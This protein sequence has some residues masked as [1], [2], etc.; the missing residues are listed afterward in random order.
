[1]K[2]SILLFLVIF[3][4]TSVSAN[5]MEVMP[6]SNNVL[7]D[8]WVEVYN[9]GN[10]SL[11][12]T[13]IGDSSSNDSISL[14]LDP[15]SFGLIIDSSINC[16]NF[17]VPCYELTTIGNG[18]KD[19]EETIYLW[20]GDDLIG[21]FS[22]NESI[23]DSGKSF[24]LI[25]YS[26]K[27]CIPTPGFENNCSSYVPGQKKIELEY[28]TEVPCSENFTID[29]KAFDFED[30]FYD[31]KI[32]ILSVEEDKRIAKVWDGDRW[33]STVSY[34]KEIFNSF[35]NYGE[36]SLTFTVDCFIGD[37]VLLPRIRKT[38]TS[39][40]TDFDPQYISVRCTNP[41]EEENESKIEIL[42]YP[43]DAKFGDT[44]EIDV[45]IYKGNTA[46]YSISA[47]LEN[48]DGKKVSEETKISL[49]S[50]YSEYEGNFL[51]VL[52]CKDEIGEF[53]IVVEGLGEK[54]KQ[55]IDVESCHEETTETRVTS[56]VEN[57]DF[58][59]E[60]EDSYV[61]T[62]EIPIFTGAVVQDTGKSQSFV[63]T[64]LFPYIFC[65]V[66]LLAIIYLII[67]KI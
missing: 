3:L 27:Q 29:L 14:I 58:T 22:W 56:T 53:D 54:S 21:N 28:E 48:K 41:I 52:D 35:E 67:K 39:S 40:Y 49:K 23:K 50:K 34:I 5:L 7:G 38:N 42:D 2:K 57:T 64:E 30:G 32:D 43:D 13:K 33:L 62:G 51:I 24:G 19:S 15:Y 6:H 8:E 10:T 18:L 66:C 1:M 26:W 20:S 59:S 37:A 36:S 31:V 45:Y 55:E 46:K 9:F 16:S 44:I 17:S 63:I 61:Y 4:L 12:L 11:N 60:E 25:N 47:Y 65:T